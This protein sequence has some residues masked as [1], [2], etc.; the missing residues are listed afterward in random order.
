[1]TP[2]SPREQRVSRNEA[3]FREVNVHIAG[4]EERVNDPSELLPLFC[5]CARTGCLAPIEVER[6]T[7]EAV[8]EKPRRFLVLPGHEEPEVESVIERHLG[9]LIVE[10]HSDERSLA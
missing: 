1:M 6:A 9:Y 4:L 8:R 2:M 10:K 7:F 5:E 3:L